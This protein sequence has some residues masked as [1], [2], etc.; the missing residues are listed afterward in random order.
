MVKKKKKSFLSKEIIFFFRLFS[1]C[2]PGVHVVY[3]HEETLHVEVG[4]VIPNYIRVFGNFHESDFDLDFFK[5]VLFVE[6]HNSDS[7]EL[8]I[9]LLLDCLVD[10]TH[11]TFSQLI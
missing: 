2:L 10:L 6:L 3:D 9:V 8:A 1:F 7:V 5:S 4:F 11:G